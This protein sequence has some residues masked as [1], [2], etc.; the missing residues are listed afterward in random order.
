MNVPNII[1]IGRIFLVPVVVWAIG[2]HQYALAFWLFLA[3][4]ISDGI[5]GFIA[6]RFD[7]ASELG[8]YLD[9]LADK[10]LLVSIYVTLAL[11]GVLPVWLAIAVVSRDI[12]IVGAVILSWGLDKPVAIRPLV[13]SKLNTTAQIGFAALILATLGFG[14]DPGRALEVG[15]VLVGS[16]TACSALAYLCEWARH[17][18]E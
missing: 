11:A 17:V 9:P 13:I 4:G 1:T 12:M 16:L 10:A 18:A 7:L 8:A 3:A 14:L 2:A 6:K 5:D 15:M